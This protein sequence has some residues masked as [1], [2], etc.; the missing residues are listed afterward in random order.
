MVKHLALLL[1]ILSACTSGVKVDVGRICVRP[2]SEGAA[3]KLSEFAASAECIPLETTDSVIINNP[4]QIILHDGYEYIADNAGVYKFERGKWVASVLRRGNAPDEYINVS[5]FLITKQGNPLVL[6]RSNRALFLYTWDGVLQKKIDLDVWAQRMAWINDEE[7]VLFTGH[8]KDRYNQHKLCILGLQTER[9]VKQMLP[10]DDD[11]SH[12]LHVNSW[13]HFYRSD[14]NETF[15]YQTFCD[16]VYGLSADNGLTPEYVMDWEGKNIPESFYEHDYRDVMD[17]F[18]NLSK[19]GY[20]YGI[21]LFMQKGNK[22]WLSYLYNGRLFLHS[23]MNH[24]GKSGNVL[25]DDL[26][27]KGYRFNMEDIS[28]F[29]QN[30]GSL[31]I[32]IY[33]YLV[34]EYA[35][36]NLNNLEC[37]KIKDVL[38]YVGEEQNPVL[39]R[40]NM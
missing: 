31:V 17:F 11:K 1:F 38:Q 2:S 37:Q 8:E 34:M 39:L 16:T 32:P 29:V 19:G 21:D 40:I 9:I 3:M 20:A 13:N 6:S 25:I 10:I 5:D 15:F 26:C 7:I 22:F 33:P 36:E 24:T 28:Y 18:Q 23:S 35:K 12:Y 14:S 4:V 27:L 30:E